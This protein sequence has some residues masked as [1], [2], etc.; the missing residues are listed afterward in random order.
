MELAL[1][2]L[3]AMFNIFVLVLH[4]RRFG[5]SLNPGFLVLSFYVLIAC[6]AVPAYTLLPEDATTSSFNFKNITIIPYV[7]YFPAMYLMLK[8]TFG[9]HKV[10]ATHTVSCSPLKLKLFTYAYIISATVAVFLMYK[11]I[12]SQSVLD[13]LAQVRWNLYRG[14]SIQVYD[15]LFEHLFVTFTTFFRFP[16]H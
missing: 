4:I 3:Y 16:Q 9:F 11:A 2:Y 5:L 13:N 6:M 10:I 12:M 1:V 8:P 14:E 15:N 7:I